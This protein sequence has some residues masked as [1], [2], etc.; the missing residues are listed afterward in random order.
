[1][2]GAGRRV[3]GLTASVSQATTGARRNDQGIGW[4]GNF[5]PGDLLYWTAGGGGSGP[6]TLDFGTQKLSAIGA[7]IQADYFG[8]FT[9]QLT[10]FDSNGVNL[11]SF[12]ENGNSTSSADNSA[13]FIGLMSTSGDIS[14][15]VFAVT[16]ATNN[17]GDFA[18]NH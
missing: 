17:P 2:G 13:I 11:G 8:A 16:A 5:A 1:E 7:Q 9:A 4:G 15:V 10:A 6:V 18:L 12:T 14:K 3:G